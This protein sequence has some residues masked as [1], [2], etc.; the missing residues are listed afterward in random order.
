MPTAIPADSVGLVSPKV[1]H[2]AEPLALACGRTLN[3]YQLIYETYGELN[4]A[5]SNAVLIC[6]ALSGHHHAAGFHNMDENK[7][8]W[9]DSCIGPGKAIDTN[10]FFVVSLNNLGGCNG[11]TG[12][13]S[14]NPLTGKPYG[15]DF[16]VV[17]VED[18]V[19]SQAR[20]A[21]VLGIEQWAAVVGGSLGGMQAMQWS[22]SYPERVRHC[23]AIASA[24]KLSA[25]NIA[26]NEVARQAILSDPEFHGGH[27]QEQNV[28]PKRGLMLARMVGHI[29]YLSDDAMGTKFGRGLKSEKL[30][31]DFNSV[32]FQVESYLRYQ[33][34]EFSSR[35]DANTY[36]LMTKALDYFDPAAAF[37]DDLAKA[38]STAKADF[39]VISFT[40]DW[41]FSPERSHEIVDALMAAR[42]NVCYLEIDAPQGHDAFLIPIPRYLQAFRGY[43]NRIVL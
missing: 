20:L 2:F 28:I 33:G 26:F 14:I 31:Y 16:P 10:R 3:D 25:Q 6:H 27:F 37:D 38:L 4:A 15:A 23:V 11:S 42:K 30:N 18:W 12:P 32:E 24:S 36:L 29:T 43:M 19:N 40:T 22:M 7:P 8:G 35:F 39:C 17:T 34:E 21:D 41:R 13:S 9:W 5:R 1:E